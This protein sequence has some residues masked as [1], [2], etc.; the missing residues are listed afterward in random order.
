MLF[1]FGTSVIV[2]T[3]LCV[4]W[5]IAVCFQPADVGTCLGSFLR[6]HY[7]SPSRRCVTFHYGGCRGNANRFRSHAD[8]AKECIWYRDLLEEG[9]ELRGEG[10]ENTKRVE[11]VKVTSNYPTSWTVTASVESRDRFQVYDWTIKRSRGTSTPASTTVTQQ[12]SPG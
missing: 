12:V 5:F 9:E 1:V 8:C 6:W 11:V 2:V 4:V 10:E 3:R 7:D